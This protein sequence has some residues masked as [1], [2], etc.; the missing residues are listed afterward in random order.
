MPI[1][2]HSLPIYLHAVE[3]SSR[4]ALPDPRR[5]QMTAVLITTSGKKQSPSCSPLG[6]SLTRVY[7]WMWRRERPCKSG[8]A[9]HPCLLPTLLRR[10]QSYSMWMIRT[11]WETLALASHS[12]PIRRIPGLGLRSRKETVH[13]PRLD[14]PPSIQ[15]PLLRGRRTALQAGFPHTPTRIT[16][17]PYQQETVDQRLMVRRTTNVGYDTRQ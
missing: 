12:F 17:R 15:S 8:A 5:A 16:Y 7:R 6:Y 3:A 14:L 1:P 2:T 9:V 4:F 11:G 10:G 13:P